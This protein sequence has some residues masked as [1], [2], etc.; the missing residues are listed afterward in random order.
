VLPRYK[1]KNITIGHDRYRYIVTEATPDEVNTVP[2]TVI[3]QHDS[4]NGA[5]LRVTGLTATRVPVEESKWCDG[6]TLERPV[7]PPHIVGLIDRAKQLG[8]IP[9]CPGPPFI[10][11]M[12]NQEV[13]ASEE[14]S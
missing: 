5:V 11:H 6:Q 3:I 9:N 8:W 1:T 12:Q 13:F 14:S 4:A 7:L 2:L 10:M